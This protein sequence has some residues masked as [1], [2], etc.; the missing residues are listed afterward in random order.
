MKNFYLAK[1]N[2]T[3]SRFVPKRTFFHNKQQMLLLNIKTLT[4]SD[5]LPWPLSYNTRGLLSISDQT[6]LDS[7]NENL[8]KK[9]RSIF[10]DATYEDV[11]HRIFLLT[12]PAILGYTFNPASF[13]FKLDKDDQISEAIVEVHN[14][15]NE[16]HVYRLDFNHKNQP[17]RHEKEFH[18]SPFIDRTGEYEFSFKLSENSVTA[19]IGLKQDQNLVIQTIFSADL[20]ELSKRKLLINYPLIL[21]SVFLT[22]LRILIQAFKLKFKLKFHFFPKPFPVDKTVKSPARGF[23]SRLKF[24]FL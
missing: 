15:F 7:S 3:H 1:G 21:M 20:L 2:L 22:E 17:V 6:F 16:S 8:H 23:I 14:T 19:S 10:N 18:V 4:E 11:E 24:P 13:Y 9:V 5:S 12:M